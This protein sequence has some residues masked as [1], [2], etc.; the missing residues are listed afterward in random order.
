M[1]KEMTKERAPASLGPSGN[2][3]ALKSAGISFDINILKSLNRRCR[4]RPLCTEPGILE[5][6]DSLLHKVAHGRNAM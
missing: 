5:K 4:L 6:S 1:P 2:L 3:R